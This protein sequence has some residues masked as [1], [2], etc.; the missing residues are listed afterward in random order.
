MR[1]STNTSKRRTRVVPN[2]FRNRD[3]LL[4]EIINLDRKLC[5]VVFRGV[6]ERRLG[7]LGIE[8]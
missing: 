1:Q 8:T 4:W 2:D 7:V 6:R 3:G 5:R